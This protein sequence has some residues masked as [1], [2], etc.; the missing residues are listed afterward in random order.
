MTSR[1]RVTAT[2]TGQVQGVGFRY[3]T[4]HEARRLGLTGEAY[5]N[6]DGSVQ[7]VAEGDRE[8]LESLVEW[9]KSRHTP[10]RVRDVEAMFTPATGE[11]P[12]FG[13]G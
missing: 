12:G 4:L 9:L 7:V 3:S 11:F 8:S 13:V 1:M 5:N 2:I 10:G 6:L